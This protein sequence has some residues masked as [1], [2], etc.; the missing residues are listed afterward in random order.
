MSTNALNPNVAKSVLD[1][2]YVKHHEAYRMDPRYADA[3]NSMIFD[4]LD[5]QVSTEVHEEFIGVGEFRQ[6]GETQA[7]SQSSGLHSNYQITSPHIKWAHSVRVSNENFE[8]SR[9]RFIDEQVRSLLVNGKKKQ[10]ETALEIY[11]DGFSDTYGDSVALFSASH[12]LRTGGTQSN[13]VTGVANTD[14]LDAARVLMQEMKGRDGTLHGGIAS[15]LLCTPTDFNRW[16]R[17]LDSKLYAGT[18][19]NDMNFWY[20]DTYGL[21]LFESPFIGG[22]YSGN[23]NYWFLGCDYHG[24][25]R[26]NRED[27]NTDYDKEV[28]TDSHLYTAK[29]RQSVSARSYVG[30]VGSNGTTGTKLS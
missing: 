5:S 27:L 14:S 18:A 15:W 20:S 3:N 28:A 22:A 16:S 21:A 8:D 30:V 17:I 9:F 24:I 1:G 12:P 6:T 26:F 4:Q 23:D 10:D 7:I 13:L 19:N 11:R 25:T 2:L 29:F